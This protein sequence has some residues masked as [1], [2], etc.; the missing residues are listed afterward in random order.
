M[1]Q[2]VLIANVDQHKFSGPVI[3][4]NSKWWLVAPSEISVGGYD[5]TNLP[6]SVN[7]EK[8]EPG[9]NCG[10]LAVANKK[11]QVWVWYKIVNETA[12]TLEKEQ[13]NIHHVEQFS[14]QEKPLPIEVVSADEPYQ[15]LM[16]FEDIDFQFPLANDQQTGYLMGDFNQWTPRTLFLE[17]RADGYGLTLSVSEGT[18]C[19]RVEIDGEMRLDPARLYEIVCCQH[20]LASKLQINRAEQKV[21]LRN[22]SKQKL[23]LKLRSATKWMRIKPET[24]VLPAR[25]K[26]EI[27]VLFRPEHL[28][29]GLNLGWLQMKTVKKTEKVASRANLCYRDDKWRCSCSRELKSWIFHKWNKGK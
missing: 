24:I 13:P 5:T 12:L 21:V 29:P 22:R 19:Y 25:K 9:R 1:K 11:I 28:L 20:G 27:T 10:E 14:A 18:Y 17:K 4:S 26:S 7:V 23:E 16:I 15:S 2:N 6:V 8:L 3:T